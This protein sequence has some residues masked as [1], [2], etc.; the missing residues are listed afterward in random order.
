MHGRATGRGCGLLIGL[1][2]GGLALAAERAPDPVRVYYDQSR[3]V[4]FATCK[5][6]REYFAD[7]VDLSLAA[8]DERF[9]PKER[10]Y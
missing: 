5:G 6:A 3:S 1:L 8:K 9:K 7:A 4:R 10:V 2:I